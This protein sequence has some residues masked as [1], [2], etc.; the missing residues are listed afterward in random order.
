[1]RVGRLILIIGMLLAALLAVASPFVV[2][3]ERPESAGAGDYAIR[4]RASGTYAGD[5]VILPVWETLEARYA[6]ADQEFT[7]EYWFKLSPG[8]DSNGRELFD[9]HQPSQPG[10]WTA[11]QDGN[12]WAGTDSRP[13]SDDTAIH[14]QTGAG[15]N[16]GQWHHYALVRDLAANPDRLC[17]YLDGV[18]TC[19]EDGGG[20]EPVRDDLRPVANRNGNDSDNL[21]AYAIGGRVS[22]A[23]QIEA[24]IDEVRVSD[25]ARYRANFT[26]VAAPFGVDANTVILYHFDEGSGNTTAGLSSL[27]GLGLDGKLVKT[28]DDYNYQVLDPAVGA[29]ATWLSQMWASG[30]FGASSASLALLSPNGQELWRTA[31]L[32]PIRWSSQGVSQVS[33]SY[34]TDGFVSKIYP[35][36]VTSAGASVYTWTTPITPSNSVRVRVSDAAS[37]TVFD[38]SDANFVLT[39]VFYSVYLPILLKEW[40]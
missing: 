11:F 25:V 27:S 8:Y 24:T 20:W 32:Y 19:Y 13:D 28:Y 4:V 22:G 18:D 17:L 34:S 40:P 14:L 26:P 6:A 9:H 15:F 23:G 10:F 12:L 3:A 33:L 16:D 5:G 35:I 21:P 2:A 37:P 39:D 31:S 36:A 7:V 29:E 38:D 1:M 30:R